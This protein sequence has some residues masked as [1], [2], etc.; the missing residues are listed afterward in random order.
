MSRLT[1]HSH[2][3]LTD[4]ILEKLRKFKIQ[5]EIDFINTKAKVIQSLTKI[6]FKVTIALI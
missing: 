4:V 2:P 6:S 5:N 3:L 1:N